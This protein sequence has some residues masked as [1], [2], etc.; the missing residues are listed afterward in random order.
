MQ[1]NLINYKGD[2]LFCA[3]IAVGKAYGNK[4]NKGTCV[5][6]KEYLKS[7]IFK[8]V[9]WTHDFMT[10]RRNRGS[11]WEIFHTFKSTRT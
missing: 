8:C 11:I 10:E 3:P 2:T 1:L 6:Q 9:K 5:L 7:L 4:Q